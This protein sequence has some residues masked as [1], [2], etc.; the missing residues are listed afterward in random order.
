MSTLWQDTRW[1]PARAGLGTYTVCIIGCGRYVDTSTPLRLR[2]Q[3]A[4]WSPKDCSTPLLC[5]TLGAMVEV[6]TSRRTPVSHSY[7]LITLLAFS[8]MLRVSLCCRTTQP[9]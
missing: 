4:P 3:R 7:R 2:A 8:Y 1:H 6:Q 5:N 9:T